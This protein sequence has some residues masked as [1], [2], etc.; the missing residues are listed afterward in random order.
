MSKKIILCSIFFLLLALNA[1]AQEDFEITFEDKIDLCPCSNQGYPVYI[2]NKGTVKSTYSVSFAGSAAKWAEVP[3]RFSINPGVMSYFFVYI[4]SDCNIKGSYELDV[5]IQTSSGVIKAV[6]QD[7]NFIECYKSDIEFGDV[8]KLE[9]GQISA[10]FSK[11]TGTYDICEKE[12]KILPVLITNKESYGNSYI[13]SLIGADWA[14]LNADKVSLDGNKKGLVLIELNPEEGSSKDY[15]LKFETLTELGN[16]KRSEEIEIKV[17]KCYG[18]EINLEKEEDVICSEEETSYDVTIENDGI[19][20]ERVNLSSNLDWAI[21]GF[22]GAKDNLT[23]ST[24]I[25]GAAVLGGNK[26]TISKLTLKP[27]N[28]SGV[29]DVE[30]KGGVLGQEI[31]ARD[32]IRVNV[33]PKEECYKTAI[34]VKNNIVNYY[35][36]EYY[37]IEVANE[38]SKKSSYYVDV[39][40]PLWVTISPD[41]LELNPGQRGNLNLHVNPD[42][43]TESDIYNVIL[44]LNFGDAKHSED[45]NIKLIKENKVIKNIKWFLRYYQ[46]YIYL[47]VF[48]VILIFM[49]M[50]PIKKKINK[51]KKNR[52][53][54]KIQR[55]KKKQREEKRKEKEEE[56]AKIKEEKKAKKEKERLNKEEEEKRKK[57]LEEKTIKEEKKAEKL[58]KKK[59][60]GFFK[61]H[62]IWFIVLPVLVIICLLV[63]LSSYFNWID[64]SALFSISYS[65]IFSTVSGGLKSAWAYSYYI[66]IALVFLILIIFFF[67][68]LEDKEKKPEAKRK[69]KEEKKTIK[70]EKKT[71]KRKKKGKFSKFFKSVYL[72]IFLIIFILSIISL[73]VYYYFYD[74]V[75]EFFVLYSY[76][77][78]IGAVLLGIIILFMRFYKPDN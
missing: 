5:L 31:E 40:G 56:K 39:E 19:L 8:F 20:S 72:K 37:N 4:N 26:E 17:D 76:Y 44:K 73:A 43:E 61:R 23:N 50:Q 7:L 47:I 35:S 12:K 49:L 55:E 38:G 75:K 65:D 15:K 58:A 34:S 54:R 42:E 57:E 64:Y 11:H 13:L 30:I 53:K 51:I 6:K 9:E 36:E 24:S 21:F 59:R 70:E 28:I 66:F 74:Y 68:T 22:S 25:E 63:F 29:F 48:L 32:K 67:H 45:I 10:S 3:K 16:I 18:L 27:E 69:A 2:Q 78:I 77:I 62:L 60:K 46:F 41:V 52:E 71:E 1:M 14:K 33:M